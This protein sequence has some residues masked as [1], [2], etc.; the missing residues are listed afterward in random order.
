MKSIQLLNPNSHLS[1][2]MLISP[3]RSSSAQF[4]L[5]SFF[6]Q[7]FETIDVFFFFFF[8]FLLLVRQQAYFKCAYEC[9][10]RRRKNEEISNCVEHC[11]VPVLQAQNLVES[12][13][14]KFQVT[15]YDYFSWFGPFWLQSFE[16]G[17]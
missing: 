6:L 8:F 7:I 15:F 1:K 3:F 16:C 12:E 13:M 10:D 2:T 17:L 11:S 14:A 9:F 5:G 4:F